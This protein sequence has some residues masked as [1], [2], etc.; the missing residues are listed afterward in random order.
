MINFGLINIF[1]TPPLTG[2]QGKQKTD[3]RRGANFNAK[4]MASTVQ[5]NNTNHDSKKK[6]LVK[7]FKGY[8]QV[9]LA[10][11]QFLYLPNLAGYPSDNSTGFPSIEHLSSWAA[12]VC[13]PV[14]G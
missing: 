5:T 2:K 1:W 3:G 4:L 12:V 8:F 14:R 13:L 10:S 7:F 6:D 9:M 11:F